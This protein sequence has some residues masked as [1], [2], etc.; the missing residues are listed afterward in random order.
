[1]D[2]CIQKEAIEEEIKEACIR[3]HRSPE[4]VTLIAVT[5]YVS[6]A[7]TAAALDAGIQHIGES[8]VQDAIPKWDELGSRGTWHFIGHLQTNKVKYILGKF[9]YIHSLDRL[10]LAEEIEK[11]SDGLQLPPLS[12]FIQVNIS[13]EESKYGL[14]PEELFPFLEELNQFS[15]LQPVG[16]M[17]MAPFVEDPE[18]A[19]PV[20][21]KAREMLERA[22]EHYPQFPLKYLSMGM[23]NDFV[24]AVEEGATHVRIGSRL[25]GRE[26]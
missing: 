26:F 16:I 25:V 20:F 12:A 2:I 5:K 22:K 6:P 21:A 18:K 11:R 13:G 8:K 17:T 1:M 4:D 24:V 9:S 10:S 15:S 23:S 14:N 19:R 7:T 3:S